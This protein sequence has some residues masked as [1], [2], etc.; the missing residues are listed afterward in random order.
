MLAISSTYYKNSMRRFRRNVY[1]DIHRELVK[2]RLASTDAT[3]ESALW[4]NTFLDQFWMIY[5]PFLSAAIIAYADEVLNT[6]TPAFLDSLR[7]TAFTLGNKAPRIHN[8]WTSPNQR[9]ISS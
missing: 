9:T 8:I 4:L 2:T 7:L 1:N 5:E 3:V 6:N